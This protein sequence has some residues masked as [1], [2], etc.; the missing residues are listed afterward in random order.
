MTDFPFK[1][2]LFSVCLI[3]V[4]IQIFSACD[5]PSK[6]D[7]I[8][9]YI[10]ND[11]SNKE[12][13][14]SSPIGDLDD[15]D[16]NRT[17]WQ[18]P[19]KIIE[20]IGDLSGLTIADIGAGTGYFAFRLVFKAD[21]VIAVDIDPEMISIME[22]FKSSLP[23]QLQSKFET[24]LVT[25]NNA[26]LQ[27]GEVDLIL[28]VNTVAYIDNRV[29]YLSELKKALKPDG[30]LMILDFKMQRLP[31]G[32]APPK[33]NRVYIDVIES[34]LIEAGYQEVLTDDMT[35]DYQYIVKAHK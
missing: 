1:L 3:I 33:S 13:V 32:D 30:R 8:R 35:L 14:L 20:S 17:Y 22:S 24:R 29:E 25:E 19:N 15:A 10:S 11:K 21:H 9:D 27:E 16:P 5:S 28:I 4:S 23:D 6:Q 26:M 7:K 18:K 31:I 2:S 12:E 34:E